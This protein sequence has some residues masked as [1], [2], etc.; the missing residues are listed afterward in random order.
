MGTDTETAAGRFLVSFGGEAG[1]TEIFRW[2]KTVE[3]E[4]SLLTLLI[5]ILE[6]EELKCKAYSHKP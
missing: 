5:I 3:Q 1:E 4:S 2:L 6:F